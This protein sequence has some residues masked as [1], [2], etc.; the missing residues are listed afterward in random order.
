MEFVLAV[1]L[2]RHAHGAYPESL[3]ALAPEFLTQAPN[4]ARSGE[5]FYYRRAENNY[6][7]ALRGQGD[8]PRRLIYSDILVSPPED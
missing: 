2:Y 5:P 7:L 3:A 6:W 8:D 1:E 4:N